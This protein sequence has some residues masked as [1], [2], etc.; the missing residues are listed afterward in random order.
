MGFWHTVL[1]VYTGMWLYDITL[2]MLAI[3]LNRKNSNDS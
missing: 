1:A 2:N 3:L